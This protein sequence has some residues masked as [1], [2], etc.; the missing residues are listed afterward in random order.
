M[1][2]PLRILVADDDSVLRVL[3]QLKLQADGH[4]VILASNGHEARQLIN[5]EPPD[6]AV[7]DIVMPGIDGLA[8][9]RV[10][11]EEPET[12]SLPIVLL[13]GRD[14]DHDIMVGW[15]SGANYYITKPFVIEQL[16]YF[17]RLAQIEP[18]SRRTPAR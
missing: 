11:R 9:T 17:I 6:L 3:L 16:R 14:T 8:L 18:S 10:L 2:L 15:Q 7:L 12:A 4:E 1:S 5:I 13:T